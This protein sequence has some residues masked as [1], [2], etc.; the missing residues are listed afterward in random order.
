MIKRIVGLFVLVAAFQM[1]WAQSAQVQKLGKSVFT[2]TTFKKDGT[3]LSSAKG[4]FVGN[5]GE[6]VS[7]W[8]PFVGADSAIVI[9]ASGKKMEVEVL[10]GANELYD[11]CKFRVA[12]TTVAAP[13]A[14]KALAAGA[15]AWLV[16][17]STTKTKP[18]R[19]SVV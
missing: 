8:T 19:K 12:G 18:D 9:D 2:L 14:D 4:V 17:Y 13:L 1:V 5:K 10:Y 6:A 11:V 16:E 3:I 7:L 15:K